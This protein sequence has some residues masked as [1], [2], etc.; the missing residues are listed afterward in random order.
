VQQHWAG[1]ADHAIRTAFIEGAR[2]MAH[3]SGVG[4]NVA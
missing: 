4:M 1:R 2:V 3:R